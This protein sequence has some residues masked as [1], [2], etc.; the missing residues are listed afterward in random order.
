VAVPT[1]AVNLFPDL[2]HIRPWSIADS[3]VYLTWALVG[4]VSATVIALINIRAVPI[5]SLV[6]TLVVSFLV[7]VGLPL[8]SSASVGGHLDNTEPLFTGGATGFIGVLAVVPFL[9]VGFDVIPQSAEEVKIPPRNIGKLVVI[10][11]IMAITFYII[12]IGMT[13][14]AIPAEQL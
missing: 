14:V 2:A 4:T 10:S 9:F 1:T 11:V 13:S 3:G 7:I 6:Q 12:V 8:L 5:A